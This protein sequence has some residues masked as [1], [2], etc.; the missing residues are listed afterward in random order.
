M[1]KLN[2]GN[3][4]FTGIVD[5]C[6]MITQIET[7]THG[8]RLW[9]KS[10]FSDLVLG[11]SIALDGVCLTVTNI[12]DR[13]YSCD[14][15]PE[16]LN[17]TTAKYFKTN[18]LVNLERALQLSSRLGGHMVAGHIDQVSRLKSIRSLDQ[19]IEMVFTDIETK[20]TDFTARIIINQTQKYL[21]DSFNKDYMV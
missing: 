2:R 8:Y 4:M 12:R 18:Q 3:N 9:I 13:H 7:I 21:S 14:I 6:G 11:E 20:H 5:H 15:S 16:T 17:L 10:N 19:F 1:R